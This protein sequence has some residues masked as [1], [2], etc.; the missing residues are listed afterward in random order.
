MRRR[1]LQLLL[2][3]AD[4]HRFDRFETPQPAAADLQRQ[5]HADN[6]R[7]NHFGKH[8]DQRLRRRIY[9]YDTLT[10][11]NS[12]ISG[13]TAYKFGGGICH[14]G[15][16]TITNT[17]VA[18][19]YAS[20]DNDIGVSST[21]VSGSTTSLVST[22]V[23]ITAPVF[24]N[25][26]LINADKLDLSLAAGSVAI[27]GG[28]NAA[29][30]T[31]TDIAGNPRI[32]A[33][34]REIA[35]VDIGAF[36][37]QGTVTRGD[38]ETPSTVVTTVLDV[39]DETDGLISLREAILYAAAGIPSPS[40]SLASRTIVLDGADLV[41]DKNLSIDASALGGIT[42]D[43][44]ARSRIFTPATPPSGSRSA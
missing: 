12:T 22:P 41:I 8:R 42:I 36:E 7:F 25:G 33:S 35:T 40:P 39:A 15:T 44:D 3:H 43:G 38:I 30:E 21:P 27:D 32:A 5:R 24:E 28:T 37:Y 18:L 20:Y 16:L 2:R 29:V 1:D 9:S 31:E 11:T 23:S 10:L 17:I 14:D 13:N 26:V 19:N 34:W 6:H 4:N